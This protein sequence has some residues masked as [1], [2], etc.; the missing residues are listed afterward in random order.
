MSTCLFIAMRLSCRILISIYVD[1][2]TIA[3]SNSSNIQWFISAMQSKFQCK[4]TQLA[5][6]V[7]F[8]INYNPSR[9]ILQLHK[10]DYTAS[11]VSKYSHLITDIPR[12]YTP[13]DPS[14]KLSV[15]KS[16][17]IAIDVPYRQLIGSLNY[18]CLTARVDIAVHYLARFMESPGLP[19]WKQL[20]NIVAYLRDNPRAS[21]TYFA[22]PQRHFPIESRSPFP[23]TQVMEKNR[24]YCY[25]DSDF[26]SSDI[27]NR[28]SVTGYCIYLN[29]GLVS[30]SS[31][32]QK[33]TSTSSSEAE[34]RA[35][36]AAA[37]EVIWLRNILSELGYPQTHPSVIL[38]DNSNCVDLSNSLISI[39]SSKLKHIE[40]V[41]HQTRDFVNEG[42]IAII[43]VDSVHN[44]ADM[45][46]KP[47]EVSTSLPSLYTLP[48]PSSQPSQL[49]SPTRNNVN[50]LSYQSSNFL[51]TIWHHRLAHVNIAYIAAGIRHKV[52]SINIHDISKRDFCQC[53]SCALG[54][55]TFCRSDLTPWSRHHVQSTH[56]SSSSPHTD[57]IIEF[58]NAHIKPLQAFV[59]DLKGPLPPS[60][61][62]Y[63]YALIF[64]CLRTR[65]RFFYPLRAKS[66]A[67]LSTREF[68]NHVRTLSS[69]PQ[70]V[71]FDVEIAEAVNV[72]ENF[73]IRSLK[74]DNGSEFL[75]SE[76][77]DL[78]LDNAI[79]HTQSAPY[80][81]H[82][83]GIAERTN[84]TVFESAAT[85]L[86]A[87]NSPSSFWVLAVY[88]VI[89]TLNRLPN[90]RLSLRN[91][92]FQLVFNSTPDLSYLRI[93]GCPAYIRLPDHK[94]P[95]FGLRGVKGIMV[96][97]DTPSMIELL[98]NPCKWHYSQDSICTI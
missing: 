81:H 72:L 22:D 94:V 75:N 77:R 54:K 65:F 91:S 37:K 87:S 83:N 14:I 48:P 69:S 78:M 89:F 79:N 6:I 71:Y 12:R 98:S 43:H 38:C 97:Y 39:G 60:T 90:R 4:A 68:I 13:I 2:L 67:T 73:N 5:K 31:S 26:A 7:G 18:L 23:H 11:I 44:I 82:M 57:H 42:K 10:D 32:M 59:C 84:R 9:G 50:L 49:T 86:H 92:P 95:T 3:S 64:T 76:F 1:D 56:R 16:S 36:H 53:A 19:H 55:S 28:R 66:D 27:E 40:T 85:I 24:L 41:Y 15:S 80:R 58:D 46:T 33:T 74:T 45:L 47:L 8:N 96:G 70:A 20:L 21:I 63:I 25:V 17:D 51:S 34:Y 29:G 62:K 35:V 30:W 88:Y 52:I 93:F 61:S